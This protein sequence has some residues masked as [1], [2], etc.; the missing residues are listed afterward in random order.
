[1]DV[2]SGSRVS[3]P[4]LTIEDTSGSIRDIHGAIYIVF[5]VGDRDAHC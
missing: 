5:V 1:V 3:L 2:N 4:F